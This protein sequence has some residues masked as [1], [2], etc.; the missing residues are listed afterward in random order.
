MF[1][2]GSRECAGDVCSFVAVRGV[3]GIEKC[4]CGWSRVSLNG[5][6]SVIFFK[7][8]VESVIEMCLRV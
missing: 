7:F 5:V 3:L 1:I 6:E 8:S 2:C 4:V